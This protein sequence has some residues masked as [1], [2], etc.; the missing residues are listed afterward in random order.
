[1]NTMNDNRPTLAPNRLDQM[2]EFAVSHTQE[3]KQ[4]IWTWPRL[5]VGFGGVAMAASIAG[6]LWL[7]P[8]TLTAPEKYASAA[9]R[10]GAEISDYLLYET[11]E[12][13]S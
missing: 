1:M 2:I 10:Y 8:A 9:G 11:L 6:I 7:S 3:R 13:L 4:S 12:D 5:T